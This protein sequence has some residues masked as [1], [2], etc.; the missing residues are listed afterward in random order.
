[1][2]CLAGVAAQKQPFLHK[3]DS[4]ETWIIDGCPIECAAGI[5]K[6]L[7][8]KPEHHIRLHDC[9]VKKNCSDTNPSMD[10]LVEYVLNLSSPGA[11][12]PT[13]LEC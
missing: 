5:F 6:V 13:G 12:T 4:R 8:R 3:V 7:N 2:S 10:C 9:G 1:M 11:C